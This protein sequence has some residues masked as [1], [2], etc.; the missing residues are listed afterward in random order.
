[1]ERWYS[2][3]IYPPIQRV[4]TSISNLVPFALFDLF[5]IAAIVI[6]VLLVYRSVRAAGWIRGSMHAA[7]RLLPAAAAV[8]L[9]FLVVWGLN[10]RR[11]PLSEKLAFDR[12]R[13]TATAIDE[14]A[15]RTVSSLNRLYAPA[16]QSPASLA[17]LADAFHAVQRSLRASRVVTG[18]PKAL[19]LLGGYF[20]SAAIA[21]MTDPFFLE[22]LL[23]P[24]LLD[25]ERPFVIAHEWAHLAGYA[26][27]AEANFI[28]WLTC[29]R[30][31]PSAEYSGWLA[32]LGH[33]QPRDK[34]VIDTL[35][36]GPRTDLY[37]M[38]YRYYRTSRLLRLAAREG[39]DKYLKGNRVA[40]GITSYDEVVKLIL[41]TTFDEGL[42]PR[43]R[44]LD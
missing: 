40:E 27:E 24:D 15:S 2:R 33:V 34:Q 35:D 41:G 5:C 12:S 4:L 6:F 13:A 9:V 37:A 1:M 32:L 8:Y 10:Y 21:G 26:D 36:I 19:T 11:V 31:G 14:L 38:S 28:A 25:V 3:G 29:M 22:T 18:R 42:V 39:Y 17:D 16:H 7:A 23:A 43:L 20:H 44:R 30:G